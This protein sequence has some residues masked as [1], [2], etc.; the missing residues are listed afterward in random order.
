MSEFVHLHNHTHYSILDSI[1]TI[2]E[3]ITEAKNDNQHAVALTDHGVM[4][5]LIEFYKKCKSKDVKP[6]L[7][8]EAYMAN[9]SRFDRNN[10][11]EKKRNYYHLILLAKNVTGYKNIMRMTSLANIEGFHYKP[12]I[13]EELLKTYS[14]GIICTS[15]CMGG[16]V[17]AHIVAGDYKLAYQTAE[18][19]QKLFGDDFYLEIQNH[20]LD[21]DPLIL[22]Q[23]PDI[24]KKLGIKL[25]VTN[26]VHYAKKEQALAHNA[27]LNIRDYSQNDEVDIN[28][29]KYKVPEFYLKSQSEMKSLFNAFPE[30]LQNTLEIADKCNVELD[31]KTNHMPIFNIPLESKAKDLNEYLKELVYEGLSKRYEIVTD[32]LKIR[33]DY[34]LSVIISMGFPGYFLVVADFI[35]A[36]REMG[37]RVGPGRGSAAGSLVAYALWIVDVDP[38]KYDLLF[39]RFLNPERISMPDIDVDFSDDKRELVIEYVKQKYGSN[40]IAM[41]STFGKL[42]SKAAITDVGRILKI[43][44]E[45]VRE[46]TKKIPVKLGVVTPMKEVVTL[47]ELKQYVESPD[48]K[49]RQLFDLATKLE[50]R[51]RN[52]GIHAAGVVIVP[53]DM[54]DYVP[55]VKA[56]KETNI[57]TTQYTMKDLE[58]I[59]LIK[60]D[61]LGLKTLRILD[62]AVEMI[63]ANTGKFIDVDNLD[64]FDEKTYNLISDG[65]TLAI[66]QFESNGMQEYLRKMK[67]KSIDDLAAMNALYRPGPMG[68]IP[69]F[70]DRR[71]GIKPVVYIH[72]IMEESLKSTFG[73]IVYQEQVMRLAQDI[74]G[75]TLAQ[76]DLLRR[77]MGKKDPVMMEKQ[78]KPELIAKM[79]ERGVDSKIANE[80]T[81][82]I[83]KFA[84]YG[85]NKSHAVVYSYIA[86][87]TAYLKA[88]Y[89][90]EFL[91]ATMSAELNNQAKI[92]EL[93]DEAK[94][95]GVKLLPP[96]INKSGISFRAFNNLIYFGLAA[97]KNV[98]KSAVES[99]VNAREDGEFKGFYD[100]CARVEIRLV[101]RRALEA[102][103]C[104]G[105]FDGF[106][107]NGHRAAY[108]MAIDSALEYSK[109]MSDGH[110]SSM[111]SLFAG[112]E[113]QSFS[114]PQLPEVPLWTDE[115]RLIKENEYLNFYVSGHPLMKY[116]AQIAS[117]S[118]VTTK[119]LNG[120]KTDDQVSFCGI[121]TEMRTRIDKNK[122]T[123]GFLTIEDFS[124][125][126]EC[127][128][129]SKAWEKS[130]KYISKN[131]IV[132]IYGKVKDVPEVKEVENLIYES[133]D[134]IENE[135]ILKIVVDY[136]EP[137]DKIVN[138]FCIGYKIWANEEDAELKNK[139]IELNKLK[140]NSKDKSNIIINLKQNQGKKILIYELNNITIPSNNEN[141]I[142]LMEL[143]G[144]NCVRLLMN[145]MERNEKLDKRQT[146]TKKVS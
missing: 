49:I 57:Y 9:G 141:T 40:S 28:D 24:A 132:Y 108:M 18:N 19:Y 71:A 82:L 35:R 36:A 140:S 133:E 109:S 120:V 135:E 78:I 29:L 105:A 85:F 146:W 72:P 31:M 7:G 15:A 137:I 21:N 91:A 26:D 74:G 54:L 113:E 115:E 126:A 99:I 101:N 3:L 114:E 111:D 37:V 55:L 144:N 46:I 124:G 65:S 66:F 5:G 143:F 116:E 4:F 129:W 23:V 117:L 32:D 76:A 38:L 100:F 97:I 59:G 8:V 77:A 128:L 30:A 62:D 67:P 61:F 102:L 134:T 25:V 98:G 88:H 60:M 142:K 136:I 69:E 138:E 131:S 103:I 56:P 92:V 83:V 63:Q 86:Y 81:E 11:A 96:D 17:S 51:I 90:A 119:N 42:T 87:Q 110:S 41:I 125:K 10:R 130:E 12:R 112:G 13:D 127:I 107:D 14:E 33:A 47:P 48:P 75:Y 106:T 73:I 68:N 53:G 43:Q 84:D 121:I 22:E 145:K 39:E 89:P 94:K 64:L 95:M 1:T 104:S 34:E 118:S 16:V 27:L 50:K 44:L 6:I 79:A 93:K 2:D 122:K 52:N 20:F 45:T 139:L 123:I 70:L 58:D 80:I